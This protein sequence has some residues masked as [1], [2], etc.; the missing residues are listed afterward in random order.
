MDTTLQQLIQG[1]SVNEA[2]IQIRDATQDPFEFWNKWFDCAAYH[3]NSHERLIELARALQKHHVGMI[4]GAKLWEDLPHFNRSL[5]ETF[6]RTFACGLGL[7]QTVYDDMTKPDQFIN[8]C[9]IY[10]LCAREH[11]ADTLAYAVILFRGVLEQKKMPDAVD[12]RLRALLAWVEIAGN[13]LYNNGDPRLESSPLCRSG[14]K[15][16]GRP[17]LSKERWCFWKE[18]LH[19]ISS[20]YSLDLCR[21]MNAAECV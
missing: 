2:A 6:E 19:A 12:T 15:W 13:Q 8:I 21:A 5:R 17:G 1:G 3:S 10:A 11:M 7:T 20:D 9:R 16:N 14:E 4:D 18:R